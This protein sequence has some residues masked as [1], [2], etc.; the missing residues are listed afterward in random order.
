MKI[1][2]Y[3]ILLQYLHLYC[4]YGYSA[5]FIV[6]QELTY[7]T[8]NEM[9]QVFAVI[10][11]PAKSCECFG[12]H[13]RLNL[14]MTSHFSADNFRQSCVC[15][16]SLPCSLSQTHVPRLLMLCN[17]KSTVCSTAPVQVPVKS[18]KHLYLLM[19]SEAFCSLNCLY[20]VFYFMELFMCVQAFSIQ[21]ICNFFFFH[22]YNLLFI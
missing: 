21:H 8:L 13:S 6:S 4:F 16:C 1:V 22:F 15:S 5:L 9:A 2:I 12:S 14:S 18:D 17:V 10:W 3:Y 20:L 7:T 19:H 11:D